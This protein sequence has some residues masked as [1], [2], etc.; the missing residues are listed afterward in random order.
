MKLFLGAQTHFHIFHTVLLLLLFSE[1]K[2]KT[3]TTELPALAYTLCSYVLSRYITPNIHLRRSF[4]G[5]RYTQ[6]EWNESNMSKNTS[7]FFLFR[8]WWM[9]ND[10]NCSQNIFDMKISAP[11]LH[12]SLQQCAVCVCRFAIHSSVAASGLHEPRRSYVRSTWCCS[13]S[14]LPIL[15]T[16]TTCCVCMCV[17]CSVG[18]RSQSAPIEWWLYMRDIDCYCDDDDDDDDGFARI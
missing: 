11:T 17:W 1:G 4:V 5:S 6:R 7:S 8:F 14:I 2:N 15:W 18:W 12:I 16:H 13:H 10:K 9:K 3:S